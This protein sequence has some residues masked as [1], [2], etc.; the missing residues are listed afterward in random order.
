MEK[1]E[2]TIPHNTQGKRR[3]DVFLGRSKDSIVVSVMV[4]KLRSVVT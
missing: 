1:M 2:A 3:K 4:R